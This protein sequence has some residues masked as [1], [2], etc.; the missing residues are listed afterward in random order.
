[1]NVITRIKNTPLALSVSAVMMAD[2]AR[3]RTT[4]LL[5]GG[6]TA[7]LSSAARADD[8]IA[9]MITSVLDGVASLKDPLVKASL[10]IGIGCIFT[11][12]VMMTAKKNNPQIK[13]WHIMLAF[14]C[15]AAFIALDQMAAR[16][17]KQ[18]GLTPVS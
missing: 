1:M 3:L 12:I 17:Q 10:T 18:L 8:D 13:G 14:I 16:S 15:G 5:V 4:R 6:V 2:R 9:G 11:G 7:L